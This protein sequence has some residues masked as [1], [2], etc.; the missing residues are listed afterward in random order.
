MLL[1]CL[2]CS[3]FKDNDPSPDSLDAYGKTLA[4]IEQFTNELESVSRA[5][6]AGA[7]ERFAPCASVTTHTEDAFTVYTFDFNN[8][9]CADGKVRDGDLT[10]AINPETLEVIIQSIGVFIN[11]VKVEGVYAFQQVVEDGIT[12]TKLAS[13]AARMTQGS[14]WFSFTTKKYYRWLEG[15]TT[16]TVNDDVIEISSGEYFFSIK[17]SG[18]C[19]LEIATPLQVNYSCPQRGLLPVSGKV[20]VETLQETTYVNFGNGECND[21]PTQK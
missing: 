2:A 15:E 14:D 4:R 21:L 1:V 8:T 9:A 11:D 16:G 6:R 12:Y 5:V 7:P 13:N 20:V 18:L 3:D 17:D 10:V 19:Q